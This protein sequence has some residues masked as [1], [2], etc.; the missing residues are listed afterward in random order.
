MSDRIGGQFWRETKCIYVTCIPRCRFAPAPP[1]LHERGVWDSRLGI[2]WGRR[3]CSRGL[4]CVAVAGCVGDVVE[5]V[6][7]V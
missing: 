7:D 5:A 2:C 6:V 1:S 4:G 3:L